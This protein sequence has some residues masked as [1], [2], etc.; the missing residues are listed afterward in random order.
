MIQ[1]DGF[2]W[3]I[4]VGRWEGA[5]VFVTFDDWTQRRTL[6]SLGTNAGAAELPFQKWRHFKE[7]FAPEVVRQ[8]IEESAIPVS[9]CIDPFSGSG[10]T[11]LA[12]QFLGVSPITV[13]V[14]PYLADLT[15]AKL[16]TYDPESLITSLSQTLRLANGLSEDAA[17][18]TK[19]LPATFVEPGVNGRWIFSRPV[20]ER[21]LALA[22]AIAAVPSQAERRL[23]RVLLGGTLIKLSNVVV[24]GKGRRY[25]KGWSRRSCSPVEVD[26]AFTDGVSSA[27]GEIDR[28][29]RR[30]VTD[31]RIIRGDARVS[32]KEL[33][34]LDLAVFSPPYPNSFDYTDVYNVEL[35]M[36]GYLRSRADNQ[37]LRQTTLSSH[38]QIHRSFAAPPGG[39]PT[40]DHTLTSLYEARETLW[41]R[42]IPDMIGGYFHD[43][44]GIIQD[45]SK[46]LNPG[47]A[48]WI[49]VGDSRYAHVPVP[50]AT[51]LIELASGLGL[52]VD[53]IESLRAMRTSAQQGGRHQLSENLLVIRKP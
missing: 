28:Y 12:C 17:N 39:S 51:I 32:C 18:A 8:A 9:C 43:M 27:I 30:L 7:A 53:R 52:E 3:P 37:A 41:S 46:V 29:A 10:T 24:N 35:W 33:P 50:A 5:P 44:L 47:G 23:L 48:M 40:L 16:T 2:T 38:V 26:I 45:I 42:T 22:L 34:T 13:E 1:A 36:L 11:G 49:V 6:A 14:N 21:I 4:Q 19:I 31:F 20:A 15:E 25:R